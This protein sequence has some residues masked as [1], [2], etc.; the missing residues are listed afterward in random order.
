VKLQ[1]K[2]MIL[3][4]III[5]ASKD[6]SRRWAKVPSQEISDMLNEPGFMEELTKTENEDN[7]ES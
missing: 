4:D 1:K 2:N 6:K 5:L 3:G 7:E